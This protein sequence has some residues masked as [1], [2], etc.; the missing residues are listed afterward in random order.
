MAKDEM[1]TITEDRW[2]EDIWN[3]TPGT[4]DNQELL[5]ERSTRVMPR[6]KLTF[7]FGEKVVLRM[8]PGKRSP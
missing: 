3:V 7:Y 4:A 1:E 2:D 6:P 8:M 5:E